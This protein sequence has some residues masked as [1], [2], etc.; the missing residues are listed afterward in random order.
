M[1][2]IGIDIG[3]G[4][5]NAYSVYETEVFECMF[6]SILSAG[7]NLVVESNIVNPID[8]EFDGDRYFV[9]DLAQRE[10]YQKMQNLTDCK[11]GVCAE[12]LLVSA[13]SEVVQTSEV[14]IM[15]GV[16][17]KAFNKRNLKK[18]ESKYK[19]KKYVITNHISGE[20]LTFTI[21]EVNICREGDGAL[22]WITKDLDI[23]DRPL[24]VVNVGF[25]TTEFCYYDKGFEYRDIF[26]TSKEI[27]N[28]S[29]L[30]NI[31]NYIMNSNESVMLDMCDI[32]TSDEYDDL[33]LKYYQLLSEQIESEIESLWINKNIMD[34]VI[35][36]GSAKYLITQYDV[37]KDCR[38]NVAKGLF[39]VLGELE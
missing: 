8:I 18:I 34:I 16:P 31:S 25:R 2:K 12:T 20:I 32:D 11:C 13:I 36:G 9:G 37:V 27:G 10:G 23:L 21:K 29:V 19:D 33:K 30:L 24:G 6:P 35:T 26:S 22:L 5:T 39:Y 14:S 7:R 3:R 1:Q 28:K 17:Y 15:I 4:Y 38:M